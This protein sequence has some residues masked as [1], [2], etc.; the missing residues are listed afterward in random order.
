MSIKP[1]VGCAKLFLAYYS[2]VAMPFTM[3]STFHYLF[4]RVVSLSDVLVWI[5]RFSSKVEN[6]FSMFTTIT[7]AIQTES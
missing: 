7:P 2:S 1:D 3:F 6:D 5:E 4:L